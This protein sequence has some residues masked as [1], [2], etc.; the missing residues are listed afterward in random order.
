MFRWTFNPGVLTKVTSPLAVAG[1]TPSVMGATGAN[2]P[3]PMGGPHPQEPVQ[4]QQVA[5]VLFCT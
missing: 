5:P 3:S 2:P 4:H 1:A